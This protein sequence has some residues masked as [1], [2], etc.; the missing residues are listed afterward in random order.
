MV[1]Q[2]MGRQNKWANSVHINIIKEGINDSTEGR[3]RQKHKHVVLV[4]MGTRM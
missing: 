1:K 3:D 2:G 4:A